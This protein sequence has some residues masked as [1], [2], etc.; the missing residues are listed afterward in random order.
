MASHHISSTCGYWPCNPIISQSDEQDSMHCS[1]RKE[2]KRCTVFKLRSLQPLPSR[3]G[4]SA[5]RARGC[6][7]CASGTAPAPRCPR[8]PGTA[9][10]RR[11]RRRVS[12]L[13]SS[14][15]GTPGPA[16]TRHMALVCASSQPNTGALSVHD[17]PGGAGAARLHVFCNRSQFA[18]D[19]APSFI[20]AAHELSQCTRRAGATRAAAG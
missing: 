1:S 7:R 11:G 18:R 3:R 16:P 6:R 4:R 2:K 17:V 13:G 12:P 10:A 5:Q 20:A 19:I 14:A 8:T 9:R 15:V